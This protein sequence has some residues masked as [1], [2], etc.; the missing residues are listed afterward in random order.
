MSAPSKTGPTAQGRPRVVLVGVAGYGARHLSTLTQLHEAKRIELAALVDSRFAQARGRHEAVSGFREFTDLHV[1]LE[2]VN[3][4]S[5]LVATPPHTHLDLAEAVLQHG[6]SLYLE[7]PP[8]P[9]LQDLETLETHVR[10]GQRVEVGFQLA[11]QTLEAAMQVWSSDVLG[12]VHRITAHAALARG[13]TYYQRAPWAGRWF[14]D[15]QA[16]FDGPL[17]N[18]CAHILHAALLATRM[19]YTDWRPGTLSAECYSVRD[20]D[21]DDLIAVR[22]EPDGAGPS[23]V[24]TATTA[25]DEVLEPAITL[26]GTSGEVTIRHGDGQATL[27]TQGREATLPAPT[28]MPNAVESAVTAPHGEPDELLTLTAVRPYVQLVN[29]IVEACGAPHRLSEHRRRTVRDG[30]T[31]AYLPGVTAAIRRVVARGKLFFDNHESWAAPPARASM[32][33]YARMTHPSLPTQ[34]ILESEPRA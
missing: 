18:P 10:P 15:G 25:A 7:K 23:L 2:A 32:V 8:V 24:A 33:G 17:F 22:L 28:G 4:D 3:P 19:V 20:L 31:F 29:A 6:S 26:H 34:A 13:D 27:R 14:M 12:E 9:L 5:V 21:G 11:R 16:V 1:A 30:D